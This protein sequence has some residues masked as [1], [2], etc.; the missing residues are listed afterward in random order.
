MRGTINRD[1]GCDFSGMFD[2]LSLELWESGKQVI[3]NL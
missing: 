3:Y 1:G 2:L